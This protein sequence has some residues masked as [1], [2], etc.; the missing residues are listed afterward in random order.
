MPIALSS[1]DPLERDMPLSQS[2]IWRLQRVFYVQRGLKAWT[3]DLVPNFITNNPFIAEIYVR[4][5]A[6][7]LGDCIAIGQKHAKPVSAEAPSWNLALGPANSLFISCATSRHFC[8][9]GV[10]DRK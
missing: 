9:P 3:E 4:I 2:V 1:N 8:A 6:D 5:V 7:F 10:S